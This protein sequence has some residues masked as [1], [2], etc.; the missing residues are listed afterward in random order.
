MVRIAYDNTVQGQS[1]VPSRG[2][3]D[4]YY[5]QR[6]GEDGKLLPPAMQVCL[7]MCVSLVCLAPSRR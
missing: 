5:K 4:L 7:R 1:V 2:F 3:G 6:K